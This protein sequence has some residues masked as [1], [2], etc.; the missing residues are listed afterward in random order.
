MEKLADINTNFSQWYLDVIAQAELAEHGPARGSMVIR[1][2]GYGIWEN[3]KLLLDLEIKREGV[4]NAYFPLLIPESFLKKEAQHVEGFAPELAVVTHAG[5]KK[6]QEPLVVRPTSETIVYHMFSKWIKSH[7]DLPMKINQWANVVRWEKRPR[8]FLRTSEFLWQEGH[9]AHRTREEAFTMAKTMV[10]V[11]SLFLREML[12]MPSILGKKTESERFA[13]AEETFTIE[14][15][16]QDGKALQMGTS[17]VLTQQFSKSFDIAFQD[18]DG[19]MQTPFCTSWGMT[20]RLIGAVIM[21]HGDQR[22][23]IIPPPIAPYQVAII[24]IYRTDE[25]KESVQ[26]A[27]EEVGQELADAHIRPIGDIDETKSPGAKFYQYEL[28]GVPIR[29]EIGPRDIEKNQV[30]LVS[31]LA[32]KGQDKIIVG[33]DDVIKEVSKLLREINDQLYERAKK[34]VTDQMH[35][36]EK[37]SDFGPR[38]AKENGLY[39]TGWCQKP[40]CEEAL[41]KYKATIRC[42]F[43]EKSHKTCFAC[44]EAS[45]SDI[46]VAKAY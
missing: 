45:Q 17:H 9:T 31:R 29:M 33:R 32:E 18:E 37:L 35:Q 15:M 24:P 6:L 39:E 34:R 44:D 14:G 3:I 7:R 28:K 36:A 1:P 5:G 21:T 10:N 11:Y 26:K 20:T 4:Q 25:E 30:V 27:V 43:P 12:A 41:K 23:L 8:L 22:G 13:G 19:S 38:L 46:L 16:M 40:A 42:V 2:Y